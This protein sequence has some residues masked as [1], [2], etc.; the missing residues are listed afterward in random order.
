MDHKQSFETGGQTTGTNL[1][2][3]CHDHHQIKS[4]NLGHDH[5][6]TPGKPSVAKSP[7]PRGDPPDWV[8]HSVA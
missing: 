2:V 6:A 5:D 7:P 3:L 8:A 4:H 1:Q